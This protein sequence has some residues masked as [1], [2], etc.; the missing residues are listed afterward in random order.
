MDRDV[1]NSRGFSLLELSVVM[2]IAAVLAMAVVPVVVRSIEIKAAEKA[3]AEVVLLQSAAV[4]FYNENR[5]W[6]SDIG[7]IQAQGYVGGGWSLLNP[8]DGPYQISS[9]GKILTVSTRVPEHLTPMLL[10][11]LPQASAAAGLVS[12]SVGSGSGELV[13]AGVIVAWSGAIADIP[14]GWALCDGNNGTPD[15]RDKFIVGARQDEVGIAK[16]NIEGVLS[17]TGGNISHDHG[18]TTGTHALTIEEIPPHSHGYY[19]PY[20][21]GRYDGHSSPLVTGE[22]FDQSTVAGG[23]LG[24]SHTIAPGVH[25]PPY[26]ALAFIMKLS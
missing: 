9:T 25:V 6:P 1:L 23:G 8:W 15:L 7:Q 10:A 16:S 21:G 5:S 3:I 14:T 12:S 19:R 17:Q 26:Y 18:G 22:V 2:G 24:H 11:R 20:V 4:K 13:T